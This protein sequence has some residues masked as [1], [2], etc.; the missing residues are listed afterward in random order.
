[1]SIAIGAMEETMAA[2][3]ASVKRYVVRLSAEERRGLE[4][5]IH[6]GKSS[7]ARLLKARI[8]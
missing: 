2:R 3:A 1:M 6:K 5:I 7:A 8:L 4:A